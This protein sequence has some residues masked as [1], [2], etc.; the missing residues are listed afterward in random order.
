MS[1]IF[2]RERIAAPLN[3]ASETIA[4]LGIDSRAMAFVVG[5]A[6]I[7][8]IATR[9]YGLGLIVI[10]IAQALGMWSRGSSMAPDVIALAGV[11]FAF[12]LADPGRAVAAT[13]LLFGFVAVC[14][15]SPG[16]LEWR[17]RSVCVVAFAFA[18]LFPQGFSIIAYLLGVACFVVAGA[19]VAMRS[20]P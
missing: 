20:A 19:R 8:A 12:A 15:T 17:A 6:A 2:S 11:P 13:F 4:R 5:L 1:Y 18:C 3:R 14:A 9:H 16:A 7:P 10:L